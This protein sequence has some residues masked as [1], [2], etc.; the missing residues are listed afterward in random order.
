MFT[1]EEVKSLNIQFYK[2]RGEKPKRDLKD[3]LEYLDQDPGIT[4][5][6]MLELPSN[7]RLRAEV[8]QHRAERQRRLD[9]RL[10]EC[11][12]HPQPLYEDEEVDA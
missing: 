6:Q 2:W 9:E 10:R 11:G 1:E 8:L 5:E 12:I 7:P 4:V 3:P